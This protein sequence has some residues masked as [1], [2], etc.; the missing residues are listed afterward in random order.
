VELIELTHQ[1]IKAPEDGFSD[2][3]FVKRLK[4]LEKQEDDGWKP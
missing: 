3:F 4:R 2:Y 1:Q